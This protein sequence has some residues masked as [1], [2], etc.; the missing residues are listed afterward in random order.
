M[1]KQAKQRPGFMFCIC[2]DGAL[3]REQI[4]SQLKAQK[5]DWQKHVFWADEELPEKYWA[6]LT[7]DGL[8]PAGN[9]VVLRRAEFVKSSFWKDLHPVLAR[10]RTKIWPFFCLEKN[11]ERGRP[12]IP[13]A[14]SK[15]KYWQVAKN[16]GWIWQSPGLSQPGLR[17]HL[18][19]WAQARGISI[20]EQVM[21]L[22]LQLLPLDAGQLHNELHKLELYIWD[23]KTLEPA[24]LGQVSFQSS[25]DIFGFLQALQSKDSAL[26]V[27]QQVLQNQLAGNTDQIMLL[28]RLLLREARIMWQL[29]QG[30]QTLNKLPS[31]VRD[32]KQHLAS[33]LGE[34]GLVK[35]WDILLQTETDI[36]SGRINQDQAWEILS[37]KLMRIFP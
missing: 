5:Q 34:K 31:R 22:A 18:A 9:A 24:D 32:Q 20:S 29:L 3:V 12:P 17:N 37:S 15:Q 8:L 10:F 30:E 14:L 2:P 7:L 26:Q 25:M 23:K 21:T 4:A 36:K 19:S 13:A 11:W 35:L 33:K 27:W 16:K 28:F 1:G 6:T